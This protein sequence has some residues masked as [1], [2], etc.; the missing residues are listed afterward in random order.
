METYSQHFSVKCE[1]TGFGSEYDITQSPAA[2]GDIAFPLCMLPFRFPLF[3]PC[4][5]SRYTFWNPASRDTQTRAVRERAAKFGQD[6]EV[7]GWWRNEVTSRVG[8]L[9]KMWN[10]CRNKRKISPSP[11]LPKLRNKTFFKRETFQREES[12][13]IAWLHELSLTMIL[14]TSAVA[15]LF[16]ICST[17]RKLERGT[18]WTCNWTAG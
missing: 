2:D 5:E 6:Q 14:A 12:I 16:F 13:I 15:V 7:P 8:T 3:P 4:S 1:E 17:N 11:T 18:V 9:I 10:N